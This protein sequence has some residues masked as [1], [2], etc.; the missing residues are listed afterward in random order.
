MGSLAGLGVQR[1]VGGESGRAWGSEG[2][3]LGVW[4]SSGFRGEWEGSLA[5]GLGVRGRRV[6]VGLE[7]LCHRRVGCEPNTFVSPCGF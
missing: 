4:L 3:E 6:G 7:V 2:S 1:G 5:R